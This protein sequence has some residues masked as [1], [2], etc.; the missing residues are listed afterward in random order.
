MRVHKYRRNY[1]TFFQKHGF[2]PTKYYKI[3]RKYHKILDSLF[4][5]NQTWGAL[6]K[7]WVGYCIAR[8]KGEY[9]KEIMYANRIQNLQKE[10]SIKV[11][12]FECLE[13]VDEENI[14]LIEESRENEKKFS[15]L[16]TKTIFLKKLLL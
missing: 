16:R 2:D 9:D 3:G 14:K 12:D 5:T 15:S 4:Y 13:D 11:S 6:H 7:C 1:N 10:L 8:N